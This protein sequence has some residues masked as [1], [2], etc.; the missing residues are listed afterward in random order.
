MPEV[1]LTNC[2]NCQLV[3]IAPITKTRSASALYFPPLYIVNVQG[4]KLGSLV[5]S[6]P[7][8]KCFPRKIWLLLGNGHP[9]LLPLHHH[10]HPHHVL[11][12]FQVDLVHVKGGDEVVVV[13]GEQLDLVGLVE[14][15][16]DP[17][18]VAV[19]HDVRLL[20][21]LDLLQQRPVVLVSLC[22]LLRCH[23]KDRLND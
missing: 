7:Q 20:R 17:L 12:L 23:L 21:L 8:S 22:Q 5:Q 1:F 13:V 15:V 2:N 11:V 10:H 16:L 4:S 19:E 18:E 9:L 6:R 14:D 3:T